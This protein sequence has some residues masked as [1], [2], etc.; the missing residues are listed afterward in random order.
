MFDF[1]ARLQELRMSH[2]MSLADLGKRIGRSKA[3]ICGYENNY[4]IPPLDILVKMASIFNVSLD[5]IVGIDKNEMIS[6]S[7]LNDSQKELIRS[8]VDVLKNNNTSNPGLTAKEQDV[9]NKVMIEFY[10]NHK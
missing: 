1:G 5:Y 8:L 10:K 3:T 9:L 6:V 4:K 7:E 2:N